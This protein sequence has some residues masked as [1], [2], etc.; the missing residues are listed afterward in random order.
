MSFPPKKGGFNPG[1]APKKA[2]SLLCPA[3]GIPLVFDPDGFFG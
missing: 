3:H 1:F 2:P